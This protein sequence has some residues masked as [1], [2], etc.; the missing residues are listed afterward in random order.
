MNIPWDL[1]ETPLQIKTDSTTGSSNMPNMIVVNLNDMNGDRNNG[2]VF[3]FTS[4]MTYI[5][6]ACTKSG[7]LPVQPPVKV[8]KIWT[9]TKTETAWIIT[10]NNVELVNLLFTESS[11]VRCASTWDGNIVKGI[12]FSMNGA[13]DTASDFYRAGNT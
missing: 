9:I 2:L 10:C 3:W 6:A 8:E 7:D 5:I 12:T 13:A 1:E 4:P 11:D